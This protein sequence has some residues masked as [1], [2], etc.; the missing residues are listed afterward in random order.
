MCTPRGVCLMITFLW[1]SVL[2]YPLLDSIGWC[3]ETNF[4]TVFYW[5]HT[6]SKIC[7]TCV[8]ILFCT[9]FISLF[10]DIL[11]SFFICC[12]SSALQLFANFSDFPIWFI[13]F[14]NVLSPPWLVMIRHYSM[15]HFLMSFLL[16]SFGF[17][18]LLKQCIRLFR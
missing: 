5:G 1:L 12:K 3:D 4:L 13:C 15:W 16:T 11:S 8:F 2:K 17:P 9:C 14:Y 18:L 6:D 10:I 7:E